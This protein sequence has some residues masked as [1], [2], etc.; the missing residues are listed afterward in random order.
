MRRPARHPGE[1]RAA[2]AAR[3]RPH[4]LPRGRR[5][6]RPPA[7]YA[8]VFPPYFVGQIFEAKHQPGTIA[9]GSRMMLDFLQQTCD[10]LARNGFK[11][12]VLVNG[13]GGNDA[14][15]H[16]LLPVPA[17]GPAGLRRLPLRPGVRRGDPGRAWTSCAGPTLDGHAGE[18]ETSVMLAHRPDLVHLGRARDESGAD[19]SGRPGSR[20]PT[21]AS[22]GTPASP[23]TTAA[24]AAAGNAEFGQA[25]LEAEAGPS[26]RR[27]ARSRRTRSRPRSRG[28]SSTTRP[29]R[30]RPGRS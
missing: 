9:Y 5:C 1:A 4:R 8:V 24:T 14:F 29:G 28:S 3:D 26:S 6:G 13:H 15:L 7:E 25:L 2:P 20:T 12:I 21:R 17:R 27:S 16:Y 19:Q 22:G 23:T 10:E 11:K 30:S 18:E